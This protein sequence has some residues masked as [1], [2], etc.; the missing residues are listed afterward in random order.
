MLLVKEYMTENVVTI[1]PNDTL[2]HARNTMLRYGIGR[3][4]VVED[5]LVKGIITLTD[6]MYSVSLPELYY[7]PL[8][9]IL[10]KDVMTP[11]PVTVK[12]E[13]SLKEACQIMLKYNIGGLPVVNDEGV[14]VG[15]FTRT[16]A[17]RAY[18]ENAGDIYTVGQA[19]D[20]DPPRVSPYSSLRK[21]IE[22]ME[23][24][25]YM[26]TLVVDGESLMGI[27]TKKDIAF[28][29]IPPKMLDKPFVKRDYVLPKGKTGG[30]RFYIVP[31]A[32][33]IMTPNPVT[34]MPDDDLGRAAEVMLENR[35]G[36]L[37]VIEGGERLVGLVTKHHIIEKLSSMNI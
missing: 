30:V 29:Q 7:K 18:A 26:K 16:D 27:I 10:V 3:L 15:I 28:V 35:I 36:G 1:S 33:D 6:I 2:M 5:G 4:V 25:P 34:T 32:I 11:N 31:V 37:P 22:A 12:E 13:T 23:T 9:D 21:I 8:I 20:I 24:K 17:L 14:L 19:M